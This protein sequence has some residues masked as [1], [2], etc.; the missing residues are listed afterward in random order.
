MSET[1]I[2]QSGSGSVGV[3][4]GTVNNIINNQPIPKVITSVGIDA[5]DVIGREKALEEVLILVDTSDKPVYIHGMRGLGKTTLGKLVYQSLL[6]KDAYSY[7]AVAEL[8]ENFLNSF[9]LR[10]MTNCQVEMNP[11]EDDE[12]RFQQVVSKLFNL[13][14]GSDTKKKG[15]LFLDNALPL[16]SKD[17][18]KQ[19][20]LRKVVNSLPNWKILITSYETIPYAKEYPLD[21]LSTEKAIELFQKFCPDKGNTTDVQKL[22]EL[23]MKHTLTIELMAK[24]LESSRI[25]TVSELYEILSKHD[26]EHKALSQKKVDSD[27]SQ[28]DI[29]AFAYICQIFDLSELE[30]EESSLYVLKNFYFIPDFID[31]EEF[32]SMIK[33]ESWDEFT[34]DAEIENL[35]K[36]GWLEKGSGE[37]YRLHSIIKEVVRKKATPTFEDGRQLV[38]SVTE[39]ISDSSTPMQ[40]Y[41]SWAEIA[42]GISDSIEEVCEEMATLEILLGNLL[43][44]NGYSDKAIEYFEKSKEK[45]IQLHG[46]RHPDVATA[47]NNIG[48]AYESKGEYDKAIVY[49]EKAI[50]IQLEILGERHPDVATTYNDIGLAYNDKCEH[51]KA[52]EYYKKA[53]EIRLEKLGERHPDVA[54]T[55][56][57]FGYAYYSKGEFEKAIEYY[58]KDLDISIE[59]L[60]ERH[61]SVA[62][63]YHNFGLVYDSK[64]EYDKAIEYF[65]KAIGILIEKLGERHPNVAT[66]YNNI[67]GAYESKGEHDKAI[68]YYEKALDI[69]IEKLGERHP[70]V[71]A[72]YNNFGQVYH[73]KGEFDKAIEYY[74]KALDIELE[75]LEERHRS[76]ATTYNNFGQVYESKGEYDKA[77]EY[78][79]QAI[80]ILKEKL[81]ERHPDVVTTYNNIGGAYESKGE[82]DKAI[83]YYEKAIDIR[84]EKLGE[85]HP[86]VAT[87]YNNIGGAYESKGEYD[88]AIEYYEKALDILKDFV[89]EDHPNM[90]TLR[91]NYEYAK[92]KAEEA[93]L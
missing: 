92:K 58:K 6:A 60:G 2:N 75:K 46:E 78:Y 49:Y 22:V 39:K 28:A 30:K 23:L 33:T 50:D 93:G 76:V 47:Y 24:T 64:K 52:I 45:S 65:E 91:A 81:E 16:K 59:K 88:K 51:D 80:E 15:F 79:K 73:S 35:Y 55:Y 8:T 43:E 54:V 1:N 84:L 18:D 82:Y 86:S 48:G 66:T 85:R 26:F 4:L 38:L 89:S 29:I 77:I 72:T 11:N 20:Y 56:N 9:L 44:M 67:G 53:I 36:K 3:N 27:H 14:N 10:L 12:A 87:T 5:S 63:T 37:S 19:D 17:T 62:A 31:K 13:V 57:L 74:E 90:K 70:F 69:S 21:Y 68:E 7:Y 71:A 40:T 25:K 42:K 41:Y 83:E 61:P 34:I 32:S